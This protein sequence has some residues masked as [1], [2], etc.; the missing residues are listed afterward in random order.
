VVVKV[1]MGV[2]LVSYATRRHAGMEAR[3]KEDAANDFGRNPIGEGKEE[4]VRCI[5]LYCFRMFM[6]V[7]WQVYNRELKG[8][9]DNKRDN[10]EATSEIGEEILTGG[11]KK[12]VKLED[13][14]RF[15]MVK[16]I[17]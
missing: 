15:T 11:G 5:S 12:R 6:L 7:F 16:R 9:L 3:E 17:W 1:I 2:N 8:L 13:L 4:Q 10:A 14:T